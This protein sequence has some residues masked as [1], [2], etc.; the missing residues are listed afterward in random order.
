MIVSR[1]SK[2]VAISTTERTLKWIMFGIIAIWAVSFLYALIWM[3]FAS[4]KDTFEYFVNPFGPPSMEFATAENYARAFTKLYVT[5]YN[6]EQP[7]NVMF[8]ELLGNS[9]YFTIVS[10]FLSAFVPCL[11]AYCTTKYNFWFNKVIHF[12]VVW[13]MVVPIGAS[14]ASQLQ[15]FRSLGMLDNPLSI[16][17]MRGSYLGAMFL[18]MSGAFKGVSND[19]RDAAFIDGAGHFRTFFSIMFPLVSNVFTMFFML[20]LIAWWNTWDFTYI[21]MPSY[22]NLAQAVYQ[23]QYSTDNQLSIKPVQMAVCAVTIAPALIF[24][25]IF[26][27]KIMQQVSFG[28]LKG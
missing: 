3:I 28:G 23:I 18:Y 24:F 27:E 16:I 2:K 20:Q 1:K 22:P 17:V 13:S 5:V 10:A 14:L 9:L 11:V 6:G 4:F 21:Y 12:T 25:L 7:R 15:L 8:L 19:Y 26:K